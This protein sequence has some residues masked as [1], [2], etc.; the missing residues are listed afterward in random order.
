V[1]GWV[2]TWGLIGCS[3]CGAYAPGMEGG[4]EEEV[5]VVVVVVVVVPFNI[6]FLSVTLFSKQSFSF[7][8]L[9]KTLYSLLT[10]SPMFNYLKF[11]GDSDKCD[12]SYI[13]FNTLS[14]RASKC[15]H[16]LQIWLNLLWD[17]YKSFISH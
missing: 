7:R 15:T 1:G 3:A 13:S 4:G 14:M 5:V 17:A 2:C 9:T 6:K 16:T 12:I 8:F 10:V 11:V